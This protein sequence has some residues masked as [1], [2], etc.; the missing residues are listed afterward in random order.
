MKLYLGIIFVCTAI[1]CLL[2][3]FVAAPAFGFSPLYGV[4]AVVISVVGA[5]VIDLIVALVIRI[6]PAKNFAPEKK[7]FKSHKWEKNFYLKIGIKKWKDKIP[8]VG[9]LIKQF[10]KTQVEDKNKPEYLYKFLCE[11]GY[12][13]I[14][15]LVSAP[16]GFLVIFI[17]PLEYWFLFGIPVG[18][19]NFVLQL[20]PVFVQRYNR[21]RLLL[22]YERTL[23][24]QN[25]GKVDNTDNVNSIENVTKK[26]DESEGL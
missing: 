11:L 9:K 14:M 23:K 2:N 5:F 12:A 22:A 4:L 19:V 21:P 13:E 26:E 15:H 8:E 16:L 7:I 24:A 25:V 17:F 1:F 20:L 3:A 10:D 18:I 6:F